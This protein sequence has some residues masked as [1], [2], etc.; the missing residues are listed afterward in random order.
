[1]QP[2]LIPWVL[3]IGCLIGAGKIG[4][5]VLLAIPILLILSLTLRLVLYLLRAQH[6]QTLSKYYSVLQSHIDMGRG[7]QRPMYY[8][9]LKLKRTERDIAAM[10][11]LVSLPSFPPLP[12]ILELAGFLIPKRTRERVF[13][14]Y[15]H[16]LCEDYYQ[17]R[18][19]YRT[20]SS[21]RWLTFCFTVRTLVALFES[22]RVGLASA[23]G[24]M[25]LGFV[26]ERWKQWW[27]G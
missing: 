18:R 6:L 15:R 22:L 8:E 26:P 19:Q 7:L 4:Q 12:R 9:Y 5:F 2:R 17:S 14:P 21:R 10:K 3:T 1:M 23:G 16:E 25:L 11:S 20:K 24:R 13:E 27:T